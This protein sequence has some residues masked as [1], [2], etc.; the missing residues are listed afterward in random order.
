MVNRTKLETFRQPAHKISSSLNKHRTHCVKTY[1][2][3]LK[4]NMTKVSTSEWSKKK[5]LKRAT[6]TTT[7][8]NEEGDKEK[9]A[10]V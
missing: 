7:V 3:R 10:S 9:K 1:W 4:H 6:T 2:S 5:A 8:D